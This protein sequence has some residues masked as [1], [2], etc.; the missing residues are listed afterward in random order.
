MTKVA[1]F[2]VAC[3]MGS[4][5][6]AV[7]PLEPFEVTVYDN[8][9]HRAWRT[10]N[11]EKLLANFNEYVSSKFTLYQREALEAHDTLKHSK[12]SM[13]FMQ[14]ALLVNEGQFSKLISTYESPVQ[15][16]FGYAVRAWHTVLST[17]LFKYL[18]ADELS[19]LIDKH[20]TAE[21]IAESA[22]GFFL[23]KDG[24]VLVEFSQRDLLELKAVNEKIKEL[25]NKTLAQICEEDGDVYV[26]ACMSFVY[27]LAY[28]CACTDDILCVEAYPVLGCE[29]ACCGR[30]I[31]SQLSSYI[32]STCFDKTNKLGHEEEMGFVKGT[33]ACCFHE[34]ECSRRYI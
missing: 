11:V 3:C 31:M 6:F 18:T 1:A 7:A 9:E 24:E 17:Y 16:F 20:C 2:A 32:L 29:D 25:R 19:V 8:E 33:V 13:S 26:R 4:G 30:R 15:R 21:Y 34:W 23:V 10:V 22:E 27:T 12:M 14:E 5:V 28:E